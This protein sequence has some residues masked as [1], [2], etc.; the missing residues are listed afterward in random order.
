[1]ICNPTVDENILSYQSN[2]LLNQTK[3]RKYNRNIKYMHHCTEGSL[4]GPQH[5][6]GGCW[7]RGGDLFHGGCS[8]SIKN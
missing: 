2:W 7:E 3:I 5:L 1:M 6:E 4:T 8:F